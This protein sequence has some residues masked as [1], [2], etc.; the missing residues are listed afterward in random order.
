MCSMAR[1]VLS[2]ISRANTN[3]CA[4]TWAGVYLDLSINSRETINVLDIDPDDED[5]LEGGY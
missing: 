1:A 4:T 3:G 5:G 2:P